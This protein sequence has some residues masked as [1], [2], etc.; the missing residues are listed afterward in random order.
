M[1]D[2]IDYQKQHPPEGVKVLCFKNGDIWVGHL[3]FG[4]FS[5]LQ[6]RAKFIVPDMWHHLPRPLPNG[7]AGI[8]FVSVDDE[9][10]EMEVFKKDYPDLYQLQYNTFR[11]SLKL[12]V[13]T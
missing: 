13:I 7:A 6:S 10:M 4:V 8:I 9:I 5:G 11:K 2:W 1:S 12:N 3:I